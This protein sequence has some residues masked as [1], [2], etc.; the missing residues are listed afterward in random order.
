MACPKF[1][2]PASEGEMKSQEEQADQQSGA[3]VKVSGKLS[4]GDVFVIPAGHPVSI[5]AQ[6]NNPTNN[7]NQNQNLRI[8][9]FGINAGNNMR[10][11]LA[12]QE[13]NIMKQMEREATQLTFGQEMEQI[14]T[15]QKQSYFVPASRRGSS[16]EKA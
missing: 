6:N 15:S 13:G 8:V 3:Y 10:N 16:T 14:L 7:G 9:G 12:G 11:F 5:V 4:L 2:I 1:T